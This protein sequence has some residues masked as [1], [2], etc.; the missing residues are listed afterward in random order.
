MKTYNY[1]KFANKEYDLI[2]SSGIK[3]GETIPDFSFLTLNDGNKNFSEYLDKPIILETGSITCGMFAGQGKAMNNLANQNPDFN[4]L[5]L[6]VREA[7]PGK[8]IPAHNSIEE[9]C[10]LANRL[11]TEDKIENRTI[12]IDDINGNIHTILGALPNMILIIDTNGKVIYKEDWN[13]AK[14]LQ[15]AIQEFKRTQK[16]QQQKWAMLP[17]PNIP[18]EYRIF[19]RAGWDAATDFIIA[20]PKLIYLH[21]L[22]GL[23][24]KFSKKC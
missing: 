24:F 21:I 1:S 6:Y 20:L 4:F 16:P 9:K 19:K 13:N 5:L 18:V 3:V 12:I 17:L 10:Y 11:K 8:I 23:C 2:H 7:H 22:G 15:K 14:S